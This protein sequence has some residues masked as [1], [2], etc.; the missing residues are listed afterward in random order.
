[1]TIR[2]LACGQICGDGTAGPCR[3]YPV[4]SGLRGINLPL[5]SRR[6]WITV[7][8]ETKDEAE[9]AHKHAAKAGGG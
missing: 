8:F 7:V 4:A 6:T 1:M 9:A 3:Y 2:F 5:A